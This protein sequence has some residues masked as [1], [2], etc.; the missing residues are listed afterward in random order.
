MTHA[1]LAPS[2]D[3]QVLTAPLP[4]P[5]NPDTIRSSTIRTLEKHLSLGLKRVGI[6][7]EEN[8]LSPGLEYQKDNRTISEIGTRRIEVSAVRGSN[9]G[10]YIHIRL[11]TDTTTELCMTGKTYSRPS[12][13]TLVA[14]LTSLLSR[15]THA[16]PST[17]PSPSEAENPRFPQLKSRD[18]ISPPPADSLVFSTP[19]PNKIPG[20]SLYGKTVRQLTDTLSNALAALSITFDLTPLTIPGT[21]ITGNQTLDELRIRWLESS[22]TPT[23]DDAYELRVRALSGTTDTIV[24]SAK[25]TSLNTALRTVA[26]TTVLLS[27]Y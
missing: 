3:L 20:D 6:E 1:S 17:S 23:D 10:I 27:D 18:D 19:L 4:S 5:L 14:A 12:A 22:V 16:A 21:L 9:E 24:M 26:A 8:E 13:A 15:F 7:F 11:V 2:P 25:T